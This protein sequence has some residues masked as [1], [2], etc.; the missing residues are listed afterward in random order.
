MGAVWGNP[1]RPTAWKARLR[2]SLRAPV[3]Y[4]DTMAFNSAS[5][6]A[7]MA[8][9]EAL[10]PGILYGHAHSIY[11]LAEAVAE[12]PPTHAPDGIVTTS[13]ML[14]EHERQLI[15]RVFRRPVTNRYGCEEVGLIACEC[16]VHQ[17]FHIHAEGIIV[18]VLDDDDRPCPAGVEGRLVITDLLNP[19]LPLLR[20]EVGDCGALA[21][22]PCRCG[23]GLPRLE[24]ITGRVA[25][26]LIGRDGTRVAGISLIE[27]TLTRFAGLKQMQ[28]I[29]T[30]REHLRVNVVCAPEALP[31]LREQL[32]Q[33]LQ[34]ALGGGF[35]I[36][37][38]RVEAIAQEQNGKYRFTKCL[39]DE[40]G[41]VDPPLIR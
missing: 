7:F 36:E 10:K 23:R 21:A 39:V 11:L 30:S 5:V 20:Y 1:V 24:R 29:Q 26:F 38:A 31:E 34:T 40:S 3:I 9:W 15:E 33:A 13:M 18:E 37:F 28:M 19:G 25:D 32:D 22:A 41:F 35:T 2:R 4:L 8:E 27:Q 12:T 14:L 6:A 16:E 17:G